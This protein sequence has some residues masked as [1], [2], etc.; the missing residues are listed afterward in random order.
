MAKPIIEGLSE[1]T[2]RIR[3]SA[4][5]R[6]GWDLYGVGMYELRVQQVDGRA[7]IPASDLLAALDTNATVLEQFDALEYD[8]IP[9]RIE[10]GLSEAGTH[11]LVELID[12]DRAR[13]LGVQ[14]EREI[15]APLRRRRESS[16]SHA[17]SSS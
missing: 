7:W 11:R 17:V 4:Q 2:R 1:S 6:V 14:L 9:D 10:W 5:N 15:Y 8:R 3:H 12:T 16:T 13:R